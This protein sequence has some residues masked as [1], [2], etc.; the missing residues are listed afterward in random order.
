ML[1]GSSDMR[2]VNAI[3]HSN[4]WR[5]HIYHMAD[6]KVVWPSVNGPI[7][8]AW[9]MP[10]AGITGFY[11]IYPNPD[12]LLAGTLDEQIEA[13]IKDAPPLSMLTAYAEAD[14]CPAKGGQFAAVGLTQDKLHKVHD[15]MHALCAGSNVRYGSVTCGYGAANAGFA[16]PGLDFYGLDIYEPCRPGVMNALNA[17]RVN[18]SQIQPNPTLCIA[19]TNSSV[20]SRRPFWFAAIFGW[21]KCYEKGYGEVAAMMTY[22]NPGGPLSGPWLPDDKATVGVLNAIAWAAP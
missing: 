3:P 4:A 11:T 17:W 5:R 20:P 13:F 14:A 15:K 2:C 22:W 6:G 21:L 10:P 18:T 12:Q 8:P 1:F 9:P 16:I 19:E 7:P